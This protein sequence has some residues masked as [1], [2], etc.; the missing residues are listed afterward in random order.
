MYA[1]KNMNICWS[2]HGVI[3]QSTSCE[4]K[5]KR[6]HIMV[7]RLFSSVGCEFTC[8]NLLDSGGLYVNS[9]VSSPYWITTVTVLRQ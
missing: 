1:K 4:H 5:L 3:Q 2:C 6:D 9:E 8:W 7:Q